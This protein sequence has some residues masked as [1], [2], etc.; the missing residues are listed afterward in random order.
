MTSVKDLGKRLKPIL[1]ESLERL[2]LHKPTLD[3]LERRIHVADLP[4]MEEYVGILN[5]YEISKINSKVENESR[6]LEKIVKKTH[7]V[8]NND[9]FPNH[10]EKFKNHY[11]ELLHH[12]PYEFHSDVLN[13]ARPGTGSLIYLCLNNDDRFFNF[14]KSQ[15]NNKWF[16]S[17]DQYKLTDEQRVS[18]YNDIFK[19]IFFLKRHT[20]ISE[21]NKNMV[22]IVEV[23]L[24]PIGCDIPAC[25]IK[26]LFNKKVDYIWKLL[27][28]SSPAISLSHEKIIMNILEDT[29]DNRRINRLYRRSLKN[30]YVFDDTNPIEI[31]Y[32]YASFLQ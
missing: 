7:I 14:Y 30:S 3:I 24:K 2:P 26:N 10:L 11:M 22:P 25:R 28:L 5:E 29:K 13:M 12:W 1:L 31:T 8:W 17:V 18:I 21:V 32:R 9:K 6:A 27:S 23:P 4:F 15:I 20:T 16:N 19:Q